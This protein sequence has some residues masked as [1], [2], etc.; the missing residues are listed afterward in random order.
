MNEITEIT[1][2]AHL[3]KV[4][5]TDITFSADGLMFKSRQDGLFY[6]YQLTWDELGKLLYNHLINN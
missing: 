3:K 6:K 2:M 5:S 4:G 1:I